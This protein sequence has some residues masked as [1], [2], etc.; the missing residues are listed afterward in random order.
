MPIKSI[1]SYI[2]GVLSSMIVSALCALPVMWFWND[3]L[4]PAVS[5][6]NPITYVQAL[7]ITMLFD[8]LFV[9]KK[10]AG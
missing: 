1:S 4:V 9:T 5:V 7:C 8:I 10:T 2:T 6:A 3:G